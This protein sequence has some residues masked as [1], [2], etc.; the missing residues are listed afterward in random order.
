MAKNKPP[1]ELFIHAECLA[2]F[3][4]WI[5]T[6]RRIALRLIE[7][8][9]HT[10][11]DPFRGI[12]KPEALKNQLSGTWSRRLTQEHRLLYIVKENRV[13]FLQARYHYE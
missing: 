12:G 2:D 8:I 7:L 5:Q 4:Y 6:D 11:R 3:R 13:E 10:M 9:E 1:R